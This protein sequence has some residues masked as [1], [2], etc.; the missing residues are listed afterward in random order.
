MNW[1]NSEEE[2]INQRKHG[3]EVANA[4]AALEAEK[5]HA[6]FVEWMLSPDRREAHRKAFN[7]I[8]WAAHQPKGPAQY[9]I[10]DVVE[11]HAGGFGVITEVKEPHHGWPAC[12]TARAI[13]GLPFHTSG[14]VA[15]HLEGDFKRLVAESPLHHLARTGMLGGGPV[16]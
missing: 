3:V 16:S 1:V 10:G 6:R 12:Y 11:F 15:W 2:R 9:M 13:G 14:V 5:A 8:E 4:A 7:D